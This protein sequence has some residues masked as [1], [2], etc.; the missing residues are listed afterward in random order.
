MIRRPPRSTLF[1]YTTLFRSRNDGLFQ[2]PVAHDRQ[3]DGF[4]R[5]QPS[6]PPVP[7]EVDA[8][9]RQP[10]VQRTVVAVFQALKAAAHLSGAPTGVTGEPR[11]VVPRS[12]EERRVG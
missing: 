5:V 9:L 3:G 10:A 1:P 4:L 8:D 12:E 7:G 11:D 2:S 6:L